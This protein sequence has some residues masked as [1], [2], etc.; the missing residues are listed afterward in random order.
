MIT[1][2][3]VSFQKDKLL[4]SLEADQNISCRFCCDLVSS[5]DCLECAI[6][7][8]FTEFQWKNYDSLLSENK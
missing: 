7:C 6:D 1:E 3:M 5:E 4:K 8:E 2:E